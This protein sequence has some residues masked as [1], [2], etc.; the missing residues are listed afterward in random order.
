MNRKGTDQ[1]MEMIYEWIPEFEELD[2]Y[3]QDM[4]PQKNY[5]M[6]EWIWSMITDGK[7]SGNDN[8]LNEIH[9]LLLQNLEE[10]KEIFITVLLLFI[11]SALIQ[12]VMEALHNKGGNVIGRYFFIFV[13]LC[14]LTKVWL[15]V[16][17]VA[18][19]NI[20]NMLTFM[21]LAVPAFMTCVAFTG[22]EI[23]S[24][25]FRKILMGCVCGMEGF[26]VNACFGVVKIYMILAL[27]EVIYNE[28]KFISLL[29]LIKKGIHIVMKGCF[30]LLSAGN[31]LQLMVIPSIDHTNNT[32]IQKTVA[33]IPGIGDI[34]ESLS[35][36]TIASLTTI[37][38][39]LGVAIIILL[40]FLM[41]PAILK[42]S[43]ILMALK[44]G[45]AIGAIV[46]DSSLNKGIS[47]FTEAGYMILKIMVMIASLFFVS[48]AL[49]VNATGK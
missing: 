15:I 17:E 2:Y 32:F 14:F 11:A 22:Q 20:S 27:L 21:K 5:T 10:I 37:K 29:N 13:E 4:F 23:T 48:V 35:S 40:L 24:V 30:F 34:S 45:G 41:L 38:N 28:G 49:L 33:G 8:L 26:G 1:Q 6:R 12:I 47:Y 43:C 9:L 36:V 46:G 16:L 42:I 44:A 3:I 7:I 25:M 39:G 31:V 18:Q 19:E